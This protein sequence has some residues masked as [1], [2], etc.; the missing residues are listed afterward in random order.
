MPENLVKTCPIILHAPPYPTRSVV[1]G[2]AYFLKRQGTRHHDWCLALLIQDKL[3][4][5]SGCLQKYLVHLNENASKSKKPEISEQKAGGLLWP[6]KEK[7]M[8]PRVAIAI[9]KGA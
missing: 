8:K 5:R 9:Q 7:Q 6:K 4:G 2:S 1:S 3:G